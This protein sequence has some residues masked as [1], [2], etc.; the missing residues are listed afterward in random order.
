MGAFNFP[1]SN[2]TI[3]GGTAFT[4]LLAEFLSQLGQQRL[5][6]ASIA[7]DLFSNLFGAQMEATRRPIS[8]VDQLLLSG[9]VGNIFPLSQAGPEE[10][11]RF[12]TPT[13]NP[14]LENLMNR[15]DIF[16]RGALTPSEQREERLRSRPEVQ[17][18]VNRF[19]R[20]GT[21]ADIGR[22]VQGFQRG[23]RLIVDPRKRRGVDSVAGPVSIFD[24]QGEPVGVAGEGG[25]PETIDIRPIV[26]GGAQRRISPQTGGA[27]DTERGISPLPTG[28][29]LEQRRGITPLPTGGV[30]APLDRAAPQ[31][32]TRDVVLSRDEQFRLEEL[33]RVRPDLPFEQAVAIA[34]NPAGL[35]ALA[36]IETEPRT[37]AARLIANALSADQRFG[38][39]FVRS[40]ALGRAPAP[41]VEATMA[42]LMGLSPDLLGSLQSVIG[43]GLL[44][45]FLFELS[46]FTPT[47]TRTRG[48]V[49]GGVRLR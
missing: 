23:G 4:G 30:L 47:G 42:D 5:G 40:L 22:A 48:A 7:Q 27:L 3:G 11:R 33:Q 45:Q 6:R 1:I 14:L 28:G 41:G 26:G 36:G 13:R 34:R 8:L 15:L 35:E 16:S 9:Q 46:A 37:A 32:P 25:R 21:V 20:G 17:S 19:G 49:T 10:L 43:P 18:A 39:P 2:P 12:T 44:P 24:R 31:V 29:V 38:D